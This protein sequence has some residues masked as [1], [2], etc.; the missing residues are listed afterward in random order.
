AGVPASRGRERRVRVCSP[1]GATDGSQG[2]SAAKPLAVR[3]EICVEPRRG[4]RTAVGS[5]APPGLGV[6]CL[7]V[8]GVAL[9]STPGYHLN[10]AP[11]LHNAPSLTPPPPLHAHHHPRAVLPT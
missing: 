10:A 3:R 6:G 7:S 4:G 8:P 9:R 11:R 5:A 1:G 2:C